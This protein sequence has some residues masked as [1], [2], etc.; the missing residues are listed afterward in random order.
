MSNIN[1]AYIL[2]DYEEERGLEILYNRAEFFDSDYSDSFDIVENAL[3]DKVESELGNVD[4]D[5]DNTVNLLAG[6]L[7]Q[8]A[9]QNEISFDSLIEEELEGYLKQ[10]QSLFKPLESLRIRE[11]K[12]FL[13]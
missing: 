12:N 3:Y 11:I 8:F 9:Y 13:T 10:S 2:S 5:V 7:A 6:H 1:Q 4:L